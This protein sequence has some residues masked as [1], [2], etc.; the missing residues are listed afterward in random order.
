[1]AL[2]LS[3]RL[4]EMD[5]A[6][7]TFL[8]LWDVGVAPYDVVLTARKAYV[9]NWGG[10]R[11]DKGDLTGPAGRGTVVRVDPVKHIASEG[12]VSV[13]DLASGRLIS[14]IL[15]GLHASAMALS[16]DGKYVVVANAGSDTLSVIEARK[17]EIVETI[18]A[19]QG[20]AD[21]F[22]ASPNALTFDPSGDKLYVCNGTQNAVAAFDF[23]PGRS[24]LLGL[25]PV[26]W[27]PGALVFDRKRNARVCG[28]HQRH[29]R[30]QTVRDRCGQIQFQTIPRHPFALSSPLEIAVG[31]AHA[32]RAPEFTLS[33]A[34]SGAAPA[35]PGQPPVPVPERVGEPSHFKHV[36][37]LIKENRTYDQV[38][39]DLKIGRGE[40]SLCIFGEEITPNQHKMVRDFVLLDNTYC[41]GILSADGHQWATSAFAT[42]YMENRLPVSRAAIPTA[43]TMRA[44]TLWFTRPRVSSGQ[45]SGAWKN[46]ARLR[47][48]R[49]DRKEL[50]RENQSTQYDLLGPLEG[51]HQR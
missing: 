48:V 11:P 32:R 3:N 36:V 2:N 43:W 29:W 16:P 22:G 25:V 26:G 30:S 46:Y 38:L 40:P 23:S 35:R 39:G 12:S 14:E 13:I 17:D 51:L 21:L 47:R 50:G 33:A 8:R 10:R 31:R 41:S 28:Q 18:W 19:R 24:K 20:P 7:G 45:R 44:W 5:A 15:T 27:F 37:Y 9:S 49:D 42:D 1:V 4:V 34:R 6:T